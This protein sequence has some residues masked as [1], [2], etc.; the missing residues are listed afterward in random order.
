MRFAAVLPLLLWSGCHAI[1]T[2][3]A[4]EQS[5]HPFI[6]CWESPNGLSRE[7]WL[8]DPSGW[9]MGYALDRSPDGAV[10]FFEHMRLE[11]MEGETDV[12]VVTGGRE[13]DTVRFEREGAGDELFRFVNPTH[14]YPQIISY[15]RSDDQLNAEISKIDGSDIRR[16]DKSRCD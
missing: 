10:R 8:E 9:L 15:S 2:E 7:V 14:D 16:F 3:R 5:A 4:A 1:G 11:R 6:G 13:S 12:L